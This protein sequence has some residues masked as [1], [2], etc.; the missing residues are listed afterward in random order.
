[1]CS[2]VLNKCQNYT[3]KDKKYNHNNQVIKEY[4]QRTLTQIKVAQDEIISGYAE[5]CISD[6]TS[7]L[8]SNNYTSNEN[9]AINACK[10]QIVTCMSVNGDATADPKPKYI[11][12]WVKDMQSATGTKDQQTY[13]IKYVFPEESR[14]SFVS[15]FTPQTIVSI[16]QEITLPADDQ[17]AVSNTLLQDCTPYYYW[18][19]KSIANNATSCVKVGGK[20]PA[21][22]IADVENTTLY[23]SAAGSK[24]ECHG[25]F[26][27][28][29]YQ[30]NWDKN[31]YP[32]CAAYV[33]DWVLL[34]GY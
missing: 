29:D 26:V 25:W 27:E 20:L 15:G 16:S 21:G 23:L 12:D 22:V 11:I 32:G 19:Y 5:N 31:D 14:T 3:Y 10:A 2:S 17:V 34:C 1:M 28:T 7:C 9:Y 18:C 6:V 24:Q 4:L 13:T 8:S 30:T 33:Q